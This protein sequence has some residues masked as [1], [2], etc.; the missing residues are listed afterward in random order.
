MA[1]KIFPPYVATIRGVKCE[2]A[3]NDLRARLN[4]PAIFDTTF[5]KED[6]ATISKHYTHVHLFDV[7]RSI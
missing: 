6:P 1:R 4:Q 3:T 5:L 7:T 2:Y